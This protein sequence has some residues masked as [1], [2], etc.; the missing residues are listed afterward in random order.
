MA[1]APG[2][3]KRKD[4][5]MIPEDNQ[6]SSRIWNE[7]SI[8]RR[9][10][11]GYVN[12]TAMCKA[13]GKH[14]PHYMANERTSEY[15]QALSGSVGIPTDLLRQTITTGQNHLR[16]T[17]IHPRLAVDLARWIS[18]DF[19]VWV[20]GWLLD[21]LAGGR[22]SQ[23]RETQPA[24]PALSPG[25]TLSL[26]ERSYDMLERFG[27]ADERDRLQFGDMVRNVAARGAGGLL[28]PP[29]KDEEEL[30]LSDAWLEVTGWRL[31]KSKYS[32]IGKLVASEYREK[33][34][35][36]PPTRNQYVDGGVRSV[37][38]YRR[39]WLI[40]TVKSIHAANLIED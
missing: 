15:L 8:T 21:E 10:T 20:D 11:D 28:L 31:P 14:L 32:K 12:A 39:G 33:F 7:T 29:S 9:V 18:P 38:S 36:E 3:S 4:L 1:S 35:E 23:V 25:E 2:Q 30:T 22:V 37:K 16:G 19:A 40:A 34:G 17:W 13:N 26:I 24:T 5:N 27:V 6:L